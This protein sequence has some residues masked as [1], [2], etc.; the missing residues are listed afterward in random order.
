MG[1]PISAAWRVSPSP[2][3]EPCY[4]PTTPTAWCTGCRRSP[5]PRS[6]PGHSRSGQVGGLHFPIAVGAIGASGSDQCPFA[7]GAQVAFEPPIDPG[8]MDAGE[9]AAVRAPKIPAMALVLVAE[10]HDGLA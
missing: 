2:P 4:S 1:R 5:D 7:R 10:E 8:Q 3:T 9:V 6:R